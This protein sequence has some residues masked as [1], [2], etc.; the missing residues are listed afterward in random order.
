MAIAA[1]CNMDYGCCHPSTFF[2][3][4]QALM[5]SIFFWV[6]VLLFFFL[7]CNYH[8]KTSQKPPEHFQHHLCL[9]FLKSNVLHYD[10][11][12]PCAI[13]VM[14][15]QHRYGVKLHNDP[16]ED[17]WHQGLLEECGGMA[18]TIL[19]ITAVLPTAILHTQYVYCLHNMYIACTLFLYLN[20][21]YTICILP[22]VTWL[23]HD[24]WSG[25]KST[26][27]MPI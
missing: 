10:H 3:Y 1:I 23:C 16:P 21:T 26:K 6:I 9:P 7:W 17:W 22:H 19:H 15:V 8:G 11:Y 13:F 25:F 20:C 12:T 18:A 14:C 27:C 2:K 5:P 24:L 4:Q